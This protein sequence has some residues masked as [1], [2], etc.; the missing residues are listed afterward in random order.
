VGKAGVSD[1]YTYKGA[2]KLDFALDE[3]GIDVEGRVVADFGC[4]VGGFTEC[5]L[6]RGAA[7][8]YAVDTG[9][10]ILAWRLRTDPRVC[11]CERT[12]A[13][14]WR[15]P[16]KLDGVVIDVGWTRQ[17]KIVPSAHAA[18]KEG[19]FVVSL[20]KPQ[21]E[22]EPPDVKGGIVPEELVEPLLLDV[23]RRLE[24]AGYPH[25]GYACSPLR[26]GTRGKGNVEYFILFR[27]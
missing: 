5:L 4:N 13:M 8:V 17:E 12:N 14:H 10:G 6:K 16:E 15:P 3:F 20:F 19:G 26:G 2:F 11:V 1:S 22:A 9:Y 21:Y 23:L 27:T 25:A 18:V 24:W 7:K